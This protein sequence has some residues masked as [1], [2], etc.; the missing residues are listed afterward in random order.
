MITIHDKNFNIIYANNSAQ[1]VLGLPFLEF[2]RS[3]CFKHYHGADS[4]HEGCPSCNC[5]KTGEAVS[6][7]MFE[8]NLNMYIEMRAIPRFN[9][10]NQLIGVIHIA[11][12]ITGRRKIED[13]VKHAESEWETTFNNVLELI[14]IIDKV[15]FPRFGGHR[16]RLGCHS[17]QFKSYRRK[18]SQG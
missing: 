5:L 15:E 1:K 7:E 8:P 9:K 2:S 18:I 16:V 4:P 11:R 14:L 10:N 13:A 17:L 6:F 3:K 12:D